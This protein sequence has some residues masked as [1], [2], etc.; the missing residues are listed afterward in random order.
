[1]RTKRNLAMPA[2]MISPAS[3]VSQDVDL[4]PAQSTQRTLPSPPKKR[5][6]R[7]EKK[8]VKRTLNM[9]TESDSSS[10]EDVK[11]LA[12]MHRLDPSAPP[13]KLDRRDTQTQ[14]PPA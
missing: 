14:Q 2:S 4:S 9:D 8:T 1:M 13:F 10:E 5:Q 12:L 11:V 6:T 7:K 3:P